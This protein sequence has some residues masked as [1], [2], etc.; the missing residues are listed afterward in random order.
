MVKIFSG[1]TLIA[2]AAAIFF[3]FQS[4][5]LVG[6]L[7]VAAEREH[8]DLLSTRDKLK[9]TEKD[10]ADTKKELEDTKVELSTTKDT[11]AK[12]EG[13]LTKSKADLAAA[14]T[15]LND[16][17]EKVA[18]LDAKIKE[19]AGEGDPA[20]LAKQVADM[21]ARIPELEAKVADG[22]KEIASQKI[23][24]EDLS[25]QRETAEQKIANQ[26]KT[27]DRYV[28][29]IMVKGTRGQ[30]LAV[31][32]GWGFC[33]VS[34]GDRKGAAANKILIVVRNGQAI[35]KVKIVN[36]E[37]SQSVADIIP[38]SFVKGA[39]V[40]PGDEVIFTGD[41]KVREEPAAAAGAT[42]GTAAPAAPSGALTLPPL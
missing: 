15:E 23:V 28:N 11:L 6:K 7:Q 34:I 17:K 37:A 16:A 18:A 38:S 20:E 33:V 9:K 19:M 4:K 3:G 36:V 2:A 25:K 12:T 14:Q 1:I 22:E 32:P 26:T 8:A 21:K 10:L 40:Q 5:E 27:L 35:G 41:D 29:N 39:Y 31:N 13:D 42:G 30:V 24:I